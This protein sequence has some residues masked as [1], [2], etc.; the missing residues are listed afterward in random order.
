MKPII[1]TF[2]L[3]LLL[4]GTVKF[5]DA[6]NGSVYFGLG[7]AYDSST[8]NIS[9]PFTGAVSN[10]PTLGGVFVNL[11]G[12]LMFKPKLGFGSGIF[13]SGRPGR[14]CRSELSPAFL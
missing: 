8:S 4:L 11:G 1:R 10:G 14:L 12:D 6:Q 3:L 9:N 2:A 7:S 13:L 5:A